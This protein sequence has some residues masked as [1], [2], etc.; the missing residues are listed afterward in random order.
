M[1][2]PIGSN[3]YDCNRKEN[4]ASPYCHSFKAVEASTEGEIPPSRFDREMSLRD[5][6][7]LIGIAPDSASPVEKSTGQPNQQAGNRNG[8]ATPLQSRATSLDGVPVRV[9]PVIQRVWIKR[10]ATNNDALIGDTVVY[11]EI[12]PPHWSGVAPVN[13][14]SGKSTVDPGVYPHKAIDQN[15]NQNQTQSAPNAAP[16]HPLNVER[17]DFAQPGARS[18][19]ASGSEVEKAPSNSNG[20]N[21]MPD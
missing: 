17:T 7:R 19:D 11:K 9:G 4:P 2:T 16:T 10:F 3:T 12:V 5:H 13:V 15:T 6:D 1:L 21:S 20:S 14:G 8:V 18:N